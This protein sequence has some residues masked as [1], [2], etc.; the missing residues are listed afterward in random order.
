MTGDGGSTHTCH[1]PWLV[2]HGLQ[3]RVGMGTGT[4]TLESTCGL[5]VRIP[6]YPA[7]MP[8]SVAPPPLTLT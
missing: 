2:T 6:K 3:V 5:P 1:D 8:T 4:G 7:V